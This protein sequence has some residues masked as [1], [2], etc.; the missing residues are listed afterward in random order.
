LKE[1][2]PLDESER[3]IPSDIPTNV[4]DST[5]V[6]TP[7]SSNIENHPTALPSTPV[8]TTEEKVA[9]NNSQVQTV[10]PHHEDQQLTKLSLSNEQK[11]LGLSIFVWAI[12]AGFAWYNYS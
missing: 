11:A 1:H 9:I 3:D 5:N 10:V 2:E 4:I 12:T 6:E 7:T 8:T